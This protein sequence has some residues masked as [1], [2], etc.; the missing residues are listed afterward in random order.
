MLGPISSVVI[1]IKSFSQK[2]PYFYKYGKL[3]F[4][5]NAEFRVWKIVKKYDIVMLYFSKLKLF[6]INGFSL[7][8]L[9]DRGVRRDCS[10]EYLYRKIMKDLK[11]YSITF[12]GCK[13]NYKR[14]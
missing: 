7:A 12:N 4:I 10:G 9:K 14:F 2:N 11:S 8:H 5:K 13:W 6:L 1:E 3:K